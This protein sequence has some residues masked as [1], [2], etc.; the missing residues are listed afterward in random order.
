MNS[1]D[2]ND[3]L[4]RILEKEVEKERWKKKLR[5][6][7][8]VIS[9]KLTKKGSFMFRVKTKRTEYDIVVPRHRKKEFELARDINEGDAVKVT[10][11]KNINVVFCDRIENVHKPIKYNEQQ[12]KLGVY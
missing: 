5:V 12:S 2:F 4:L 11:E 10:G 8:K 1:P 7:G 3:K 9:K 6:A